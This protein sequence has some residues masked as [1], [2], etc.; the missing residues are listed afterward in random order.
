[1]PSPIRSRV[2]FF[3]VGVVVLTAAIAARLVDLQVV[4]HETLRA[5]AERQHHQLVEIGGQ[6]GAILDRQGR[7]L[8]VSVSTR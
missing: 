2:A 8:A 1:M 6:R 3:A 7:E 4:N 5:R